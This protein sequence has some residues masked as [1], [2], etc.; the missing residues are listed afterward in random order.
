MSY[1]VGLT[2]AI[3]RTMFGQ[4]QVIQC[5]VASEFNP[6][7]A[8]ILGGELCEMGMQRHSFEDAYTEVLFSLYNAESSCDRRLLSASKL[9]GAARARPRRPQSQTPS[10]RLILQ[11][12]RDAPPTPSPYGPRDDGSSLYSRVKRHVAAV[13]LPVCSDCRP[14][15]RSRALIL[16]RCNTAG[17][18]D[19]LHVDWGCTR[20][21]NASAEPMAQKPQ[22]SRHAVLHNT[23]LRP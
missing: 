2:G 7:S 10:H 3:E 19:M 15:A 21:R 9:W 1:D 18:A 4:G 13:S 8:G 16:S 17:S 12:H 22:F 14:L 11:M 20:I 23:C 6:F 5:L